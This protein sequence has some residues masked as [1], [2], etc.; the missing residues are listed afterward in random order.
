MLSRINS[1]SSI[2][3]QAQQ[4]NA[5][6]SVQTAEQIDENG[7]EHKKAADYV[8]Q[9]DQNLLEHAQKAQDWSHERRHSASISPAVMLSVR[10]APVLAQTDTSTSMPVQKK[11]AQLDYLFEKAFSTLKSLKVPNKPS[12][13]LVYAHDNPNP[14]YGE[15]KASTSKYLIEN[16]STIQVVLY[17]DQAPMAQPY[18]SSSEALK[19]DARLGDILTSQLCLLPTQVKKGVEPVDKVVVCCSAVLGSYLEK[20]LHYEKFYQELKKAYSADQKAYSK[21]SGRA[22]ASEIRKV[23]KTFSQEQLYKNG[24]HHVLTEMAFLEIRAEERGEDKHGI[25]PVSLTPNSYDQCLKRFVG[26]TTVRMEDMLRFDGAG[27]AEEEWYPHQKNQHGVLFKLIERLL[28]GS[29]EAQTFLSKFWKGHSKLISQLKSASSTPDELGFVKLLDGI[30]KDIDTELH[31]QLA[32]T[33]QQAQESLPPK[34]SLIDTRKALYQHYQLFNLSIQRVSGLTASLNDCYI[35]LAMVESQDQREKDQEALKKQAAT[36]ERLPSEDYL[37]ATNQ[38]KRIALKALFEPQKLRDGSTG[39]PKRILIQGRAGV[40]KTTLCKKLVYDYQHN[41]AWQGLFENVLWIPLRQLKTRQIYS[42]EK[43][44]RKYYFVSAGSKQAQALAQMV[45][46]H[47]DKTLFILDGLDEVVGELH[48][49]H[50]LSPLLKELLNQKQVVITSRPAGVDTKL[51]GR[52]DLE[53]ETVGFSPDDVQAYIKKF[54]PP[55]NQAAIR[56]FINRTPLIQGLVNIPIQLDALC[57]SWNDN[58]AKKQEAITM[59]MLYEAIVNTLWRKDA[60]RFSKEQ[61]GKVLQPTELMD[62]TSKKMA[63]L[64]ADETAYLSYLSFKGLEDHVIEFDLAYLRKIT[65]S[66]EEVGGKELPYSLQSGIKHTSFLH[67]ADADL[68]DAQRTYHFLH[69]TFQEFFAAKYVAQHVQAYSTGASAAGLTLNKAQLHRFIA[70]HKYNPRYE[71]VWWMVAGLLKKEALE[72]FFALLAQAPRDLIGIRHQQVLMGCLNEARTQLD[73]TTIHNLE[74]ELVQWFH[75]E[76]KW[77]KSEL[78]TLGCQRAFPEHLLLTLFQTISKGH[79]IKTLG[80][81]KT[82]SNEGVLALIG[83]FKDK[84]VRDA[85]ASVLAGQATLSGAAVE[86]LVGALKDQDKDIGSAA[87]GA[88]SG[89]AT[90][91][92]AAVLALIDACKDQDEK[93]RY[94]AARALGCQ[95]MLSDAAVLA[96]I[97]ALKD[98]DEQVKDMAALALAGQAT[99]SDAMIETLIGALKDQDRQVRSAAVRVLAGQATLSD[100]ALL[101]LIGALK[102]EKPYVRDVIEVALVSNLNQI[103]TML[104]VLKKEQIETLYSEFLFNYSLD[105]IAPLYI[106]DKHLHFYTAAGPGQPKPLTDKQIDVVTKAFEKVQKRVK[107]SL[108]LEEWADVGIDFLLRHM[109]S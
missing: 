63:K 8:H 67:T 65:D 69:L 105:H 49:E 92:A 97:D 19:E 82:L 107:R 98:Q 44:L 15:A 16:L 55:S 9:V 21:D 3:H 62:L 106:Q 81:R 27:K 89:Q 57:F 32:S 35:N 72:Q 85:A 95:A 60:E 38:N 51:C 99:L 101:T 1:Q 22:S 42:L 34:L 100:A 61:G 24:F 94:A 87:A 47:Q 52:L 14:V 73:K 23:V 45:L 84:Y 96:L 12:L 31:I 68:D 75:L 29:N 11:N 91:S 80:A 33:V 37:S 28:V 56:Q 64:M 18:S 77:N 43:L 76:R 48:E 41:A 53:L 90:L 10:G 2:A 86:S 93:V 78:S 79:I 88:L 20:W 58:F 54:V 104:P 26:T 4:T 50:L 71:I 66:L 59:A 103:Y 108:R 109:D 36:F 102:D 40:G 70:E 74:A 7:L 5:Q 39:M 17:S 30:F 6:G 13:F 46:D 25:I 83:A